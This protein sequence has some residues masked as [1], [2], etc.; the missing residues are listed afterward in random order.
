MDYIVTCRFHKHIHEHTDYFNEKLKHL[1]ELKSNLSDY[2]E[3]ELIYAFY[4]YGLKLKINTRR[5]FI[6]SV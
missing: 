2:E 6:F 1:I 3:E 5:V 4:F